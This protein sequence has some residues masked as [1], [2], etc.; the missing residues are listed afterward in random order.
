MSLSLPAYADSQRTFVRSLVCAVVI[1]M[2]LGPHRAFAN[3]R[4]DV[5]QRMWLPVA[6]TDARGEITYDFD[7]LLNRTTATY[8]AP[9]GKRDL[10]HRLFAAP[11][12]HTIVAR[13]QF[14]GR[15]ATRAPDTIGVLLEADAYIAPASE[16]P[17]SVATNYPLNIGVREHTLEHSLSIADSFELERT[18]GEPQENNSAGPERHRF[19]GS[20]SA[21]LVHI[22]RRAT[23]RLSTCEFLALIG[24]HEIRGTVAGLDFTIDPEVV[25]GLNR[26]A[27]EMA[28]G[29]GQRFIDC[30]EIANRVERKTD[31]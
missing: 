15:F 17:P 29:D 18:W 13:Y 21:G 4:D 22:R 31:R 23:A 14:N 30:S 1:A 9:L 10:V 19:S 28:S 12:V 24:Q 26:F 16:H 2:L 8:V 7:S 20:P 5:Q 27:S 3:S 11:T 25:A 6:P